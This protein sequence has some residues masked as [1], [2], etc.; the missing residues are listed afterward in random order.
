MA[1]KDALG[2]AH[3]ATGTGLNPQQKTPPENSRVMKPGEAVKL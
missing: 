1:L 2:G 3:T